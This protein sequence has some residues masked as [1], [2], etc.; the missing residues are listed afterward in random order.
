MW[1][2]A[3]GAVCHLIMLMSVEAVSNL[4]D[5]FQSQLLNDVCL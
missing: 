1:T 4:I 2:S 3:R 5:Y